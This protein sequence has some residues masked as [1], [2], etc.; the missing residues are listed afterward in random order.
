[1]LLSQ[2]TSSVEKNMLSTSLERPLHTGRMN[3]L[4]QST[5]KKNLEQNPIHINTKYPVLEANA[6]IRSSQQF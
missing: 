6:S 2:R 4:N 1:M 3:S 5:I